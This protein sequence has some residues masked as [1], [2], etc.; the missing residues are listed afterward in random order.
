MRAS[1]VASLK[2]LVALGCAMIPPAQAASAGAAAAMRA[3]IRD[4]GSGAFAQALN[5]F[6][7]A[8][9]QGMDSPTLRYN[10]GAT[11]YKL[12]RDA[13]AAGEFRSLLSDPKFSDFAR[14]NLGL[15]A[16]R[17]G[18]RREA[19]EYFSQVAEQ[20]HDAHLKTLARAEL[21]GRPRRG[22]HGWQGF[23]EAGGGYDDNVALTARNSL[24]AASGASSKVY[25][26]M[27]GGGGWL[28]GGGGRGL[29]F[30][31]SI[32][33]VQYPDQSTF[34]LLIA[35]AGPEYLLPMHSWSLR[36]AASATRINLGSNEL[37][38]F[39]A[40]N[41]RGEHSLGSARLRLAYRLERING[42]PRYGY[43]SGWRNQ[44]GVR[45]S[46][47]PGSVE[48]LFGYTFTLNQRQD[49]TTPTQFFSVSPIR[50]QVD[51]ELRWNATLRSTFYAHGYYWWSLYRDP[52][53]FLQ[54]GALQQLRR[55]DNERVAEIGVLYRLT[56]KMR[57][58]AEYGLRHND[59]NITRYSYT[60]N[61]Y[62]LSLQYAF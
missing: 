48:M 30:G 26:V 44:F 54:A 9:R 31:G 28:A 17:A 60:S 41:L 46:W 14:Y 58:T 37:E 39:G 7:E 25:S 61:R 18:Q 4:F 38:T 59:S 24:L 56:S 32:Y 22:P 36:A 27:A 8:S 11:Y 40:L 21:R 35:Q 19:K 6:Q 50:N 1:A 16:Q 51:A 20:A 52:N 2:V 3:G 42:G 33:D 34:N 62:M 57:L 10:L 55:A 49:L 45:T 23:A 43:L 5:E 15:I 53:R 13:E 29:R 12:G 47:H